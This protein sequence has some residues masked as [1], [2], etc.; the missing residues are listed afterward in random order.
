MPIQVS[1]KDCPS[2]HSFGNKVARVAWAVVWATM[3][4]CSPRIFFGWRRLLLRLFGASIGRNARISP[5]VKVW[6]PWNLVVGDEAA[7]AHST[8]YYCVDRLTIGN[9]ATV[10][11]YSYLCTA[12]HDPSDPNMKLTSAPIHISDQAW[13]CA[14]AFVAPGVTLAE[15]AVAGAMSVV[16]KNV[17]AWTIVAGNPAKFIRKRELAEANHE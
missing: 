16:T 4:R 11:Q 5:S 6:G 14:G 9:H 13:V 10:S 15:G 1:K 2:P 7:I 3:F 8:D 17:D 12:S